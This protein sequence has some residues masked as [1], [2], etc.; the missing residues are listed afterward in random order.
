MHRVNIVHRFSCAKQFNNYDQIC[1][2]VRG[3]CP[4][5]N[6]RRADR[7]RPSSDSTEL[8][9]VHSRDEVDLVSISV[10]FLVCF[11]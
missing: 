4:S 11:T 8:G 10:V 9:G 1:P 3:L 5:F 2:N 7:I 6:N